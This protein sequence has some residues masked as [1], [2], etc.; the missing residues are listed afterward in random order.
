MSEASILYSIIDILKRARLTLGPETCAALTMSRLV[1]A[2]HCV[3]RTQEGLEQPAHCTGA[4]SSEFFLLCL[5]RLSISAQGRMVD[6][7][8]LI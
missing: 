5:G 4:F 2:L 7:L 8:L 3:V 6:F 1:Q